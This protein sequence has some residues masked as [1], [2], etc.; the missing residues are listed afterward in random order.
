MPVPLFRATSV[1]AVAVA[2]LA[3]CE[4]RAQTAP[5]APTTAYAKTSPTPPSARAVCVTDDE[6]QAVRNEIAWQ[7]FYNAAIVCRAA[8]PAFASE[9]G[10]FRNKFRSDN[11]MNQAALQRAANK[12][13]SNINTM[14]T[15]IANRDGAMPGSN[16][17]YCAEA[18]QGFRWALSRQ[19]NNIA[20]VPPML[21]FSADLGVKSCSAGAAPPARR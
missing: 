21:D 19:V 18:Q 17:R 7:Q 8:T 2:V 11:E 13:R 5:P 9:Y 20:Q 4:Q 16:P 3:A 15:E 10:A 14:K 12:R 6:L 1:A